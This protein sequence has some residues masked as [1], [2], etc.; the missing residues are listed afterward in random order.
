MVTIEQKLTLFSK[1]LNQD[2]KEENDKKLMA[3]EK[4]YEKKIAENKFEVNKECTEI[5]EQ[6]RRRA[7]IKKV[8]LMSK[9]RLSSKKEMMIIKEKMITQFML[10]LE[11]KVKAFVQTEAYKT[12][13]ET[14]INELES[15]KGQESHLVVYLTDSDYQYNQD[16]IR[17]AF[18]NIGLDVQKLKFEIDSKD[19]MGGMI[20]KDPVLNTRIDESIRTLI[21]EQKDRIVE[22]ISIAIGEVGEV[23]HE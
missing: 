18:N 6:A 23:A 16:F 14:V 5:I 20:I 22:R 15:L 17:T 10:E 4:E 12:Y 19:I 8:E 21:N 3:L 7:E 1:L 2:L 13:L 11:K 9:G